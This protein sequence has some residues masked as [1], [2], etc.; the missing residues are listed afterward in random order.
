MK[1]SINTCSSCGR[2]LEIHE[3]VI[4]NN[5]NKRYCK[6]CYKDLNREINCKYCGKGMPQYDYHNHIMNMHCK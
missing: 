4:L 2:E 5:V 6:E 1:I 3:I